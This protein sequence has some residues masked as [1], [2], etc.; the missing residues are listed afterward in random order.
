MYSSLREGSPQLPAQNPSC[1]GHFCPSGTSRPPAAARGPWLALLS[2]PA[3][4]SSLQGIVLWGAPDSNPNTSLVQA[5]RAPAL[6]PRADWHPA[7]HRERSSG[8]LSPTHRSNYTTTRIMDLSTTR[9]LD[10]FLTRNTRLLQAL[11]LGSFYL[12]AGKRKPQGNGQL[13]GGTN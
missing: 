3:T 9:N 2:A 11:P 5:P 8:I 13:R 7:P 6:C 12:G 4:S 10:G 1:G